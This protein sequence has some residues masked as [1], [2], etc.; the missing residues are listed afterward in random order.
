MKYDKAPIEQYIED[1]CILGKPELQ[2]L[3]KKSKPT[4]HRWI[5]EGKFP[6]PSLIQ[7]GRSYWYFSDYQKWLKSITIQK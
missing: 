3:V 4:L 2:T 7:G 6:K 1:K 5:R